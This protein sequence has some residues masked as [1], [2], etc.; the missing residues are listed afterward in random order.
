M[1]INRVILLITSIALLCLVSSHAMVLPSQTPHS[2]ICENCEYLSHDTLSTHW[3]IAPNQLD[4]KTL[5]QQ[6]SKKYSATTTFKELKKGFALYTQA[7][8]AVIRISTLPPKGSVKSVSQFKPDFYI[9]T[10]NSGL[11]PLQEAAHLI[12]TDEALSESF[13]S[14][15]TQKIFQL[16]SELGSGKIILLAKPISGHE[17]ERFN[18]YIFDKFAPTDLVIKTNKANYLYEDELITTITLSD[19]TS[20]Y[21]L[22]TIEAALV[23]PN[24]EKTPLVLEKHED[25]SYTAK[26]ILLS[27]TNHVGGNW[28]VETDV[29]ATVNGYVIKRQANTAFSFALPSAVI[30]EIKSSASSPLTFIATV[31]VA[32]ASRYALQGVLFTDN[33]ETKKIPLEII[34]TSSW[35]TP[36]NH[37][38]L[39]SLASKNPNT[40]SGKFYLGALELIDYG[41]LKPVFTYNRF[42]PIDMHS[43]QN[44]N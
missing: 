17:N 43:Q 26:T 6:I 11:L 4:Q 27:E 12:A 38:I 16:K 19:N 20:Q 32:T 41:Q 5:H 23:S 8:G 18:I 1:K 3:P 10:P 31:N 14:Q 36:G 39:F 40:T 13:F 9:K 28:Y 22:D 29:A 34:Q 15:N 25:N 42:I 7:P 33:L 30:K 44:A 37:E 24:G 35:L 21:P 2:Y